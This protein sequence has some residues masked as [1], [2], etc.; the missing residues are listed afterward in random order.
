MEYRTA[1]LIKPQLEQEIIFIL[2]FLESN[3]KH[4]LNVSFGWGCS[5]DDDA[6]YQP[7][8]LPL[9]G[10]STFIAQSAASGIFSLGE[11]DF[12]I[13]SQDGE[14]S[15]LLCHE[16]DIHVTAK[17]SE[18]AQKVAAEWKARGYAPYEIIPKPSVN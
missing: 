7:K 14:I 8:P 13:E 15:F 11:G 16:S 4:N 2:H 10:L 5:L 1:I 12:S 3:N 6:L 9:S 18:L 17:K